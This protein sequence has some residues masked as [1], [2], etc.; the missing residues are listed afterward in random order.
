MFVGLY[1]SHDYPY[2]ST[3]E[4]APS[5]SSPGADKAPEAVPDA[6]MHTGTMKERRPRATDLIITDTSAAG[7]ENATHSSSPLEKCVTLLYG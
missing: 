6:Y 7:G 3:L 2:Q 1:V 4:K 5:N